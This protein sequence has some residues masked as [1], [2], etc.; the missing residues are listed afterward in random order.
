MRMRSVVVAGLALALVPPGMA[1]AEG[2]LALKRVL[3]ST[4]GVGYFEYEAEVD[5]EARLPLTVRLDQVDDVLKSLVVLDDRGGVGTISLPG[6]EPLSELFREL[7]FGE[8]DLASPVALLNALRGAEIEVLGPRAVRG[9]L[10]AVS[11]EQ[12]VLPEGGTILRHRL[13]VLAPDGVRQIVL[14]EAEAVRFTSPE[15]Q[16]QL[17]RALQAIARHGERE[18]RTLEVLATGEGRRTLRLGYVVAAPLWKSAYRVTL[19]EAGSEEPGLFQGFAVLENLSGEDWREVE[20]TVVSGQPV[21]FRQALYDAYFVS[22]PEVPVEVAGRIMPRV[23]TGA[24]PAE[25]PRAEVMAA[26]PAPLQPTMAAR[27]AA[28]MG[29]MPSPPPPSRPAQLVEAAADE[30]AT[31]VVFRVPYP[32]SV[33]SGHSLMVPLISRA[34]PAERVSLFQPETHPRHPL[35]TLRITN[36]GTTGLPPGILTLYEP[37]SDD[38]LA[39]VGD[40]RLGAFPVGEE[41]LVSYA[42]DEKVTVDRDS[43]TSERITRV[44]IV[45]GVLELARTERQATVYAIR[46]AAA[47]PRLVV[48]EQ[49]VRPGWRLVE[50]DPARVEVA[51]ERYRL[52]TELAAGASAALEVVQE[53]P[54]T[55]RVA[56]LDMRDSDLALWVEA[57]ELP[58]P[59]RRALA[60]VQRLRGNVAERRRVLE[61]LESHART[62]VDDQGRL[63]ANLQAVP[64]DSDLHR[65]YLAELTDHEDLLARLRGEIAAARGGVEQAEELLRSHVR[66]LNL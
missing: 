10:L 59:L 50:P 52:R 8:H 6:R 13:S 37:M 24:R 44:R 17:D 27:G 56:L 51:G 32:V 11:A 7:P 53:R 62:V 49:P 34:L 12:T 64:R 22:R 35:A 40:A 61:G 30:A 1:A 21:T 57:R 19:P 33:A 15:L 55:Q 14:E 31:Q 45:D 2:E 43:R 16:A 48:I 4:G 36:D 28:D 47:E 9:R 58:D 39:F 20:L 5:G 65:R 23:D 18:R 63:R 3:L 38:R 42:L 41:R 66:G 25:L 29:P 54:V 26:M 46:G 60:E